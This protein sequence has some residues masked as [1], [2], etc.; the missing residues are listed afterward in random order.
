VSHWILDL[1]VHRADLPLFPGSFF[2]EFPGHMKHFGLGLWHSLPA[3]VLVEG[4]LFA[5][6]VFLYVSAT[7]ATNRAGRCGFWALVAVLIGSYGAM[8]AGPPPPSV[9]A[10]GWAGQLQWLLVGWAYWMDAQRGARRAP[11][12]TRSLRRT[13]L[14]RHR[15]L[16]SASGSRENGVEGRLNG[17]GRSNQSADTLS[18]RDRSV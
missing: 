17:Q 12:F 18:Q 16:A 5:G 11:S 15:V 2:S 13:D 4:L 6:G 14:L 8:L 10:I 3:T 9:A 1:V 7:K